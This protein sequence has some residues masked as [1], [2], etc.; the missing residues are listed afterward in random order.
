[1]LEGHPSIESR[2]VGADAVE[3]RLRPEA[4]GQELLVAVAARATLLRYESVERSLEEIFI[5]A[6]GGEFDSNGD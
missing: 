6:A 5:E 4:D 3:L 2:T 1:L